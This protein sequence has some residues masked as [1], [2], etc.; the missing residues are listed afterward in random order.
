[1]SSVKKPWPVLKYGMLPSSAWDGVGDAGATS[2]GSADAGAEADGDGESGAFEVE[3]DGEAAVVV[4]VS[5]LELHPEKSAR[6]MHIARVIVNSFFI[7]F[8]FQSCFVVFCTFSPILMRS[9]DRL[10]T[11]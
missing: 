8:S 4:S 6:S 2:D 1:M 10:D 11:N 3:A 5:V 9:A 7:F